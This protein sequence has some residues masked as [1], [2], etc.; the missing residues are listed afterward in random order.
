MKMQL[1]LFRRIHLNLLIEIQKNPPESF[2]RAGVLADMKVH[3][4]TCMYKAGDKSGLD[5]ALMAVKDLEVSD[6]KTVSK[7]NYDVW[8]SGA[9]MRIAE[10][11]KEDNLEEAKKHLQM[12]KEIID[13]NADL[14]LRAE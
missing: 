4:Y 10:M 13:T 3:W 6:E 1:K 11:L 9:H 5:R 8:L 7:Y 14:K 2:N 12:A